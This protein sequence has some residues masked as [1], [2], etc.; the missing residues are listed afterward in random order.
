VKALS[1]NHQGQFPSVT[2]SFNLA[3]N[4]ALGSAITAIDKVQA[5][6]AH[7]G[8]PCRPPSRARQNRSKNSLSNEALLILAALVNRLYRSR[9][10]LRKLYSP[11]HHSF[12]TLPSAGVGSVLALDAFLARI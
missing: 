12:P 11:G 8:Q 4:A 2:V 6:I 3:P 5:D 1:I 7:A 9:R 10:S